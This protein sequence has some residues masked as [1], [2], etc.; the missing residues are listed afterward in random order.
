MKKCLLLG[1]IVLFSSNAA[2]NVQ[3]T[4]YDEQEVANEI[5]A[6]LEK[7]LDQYPELKETLEFDIESFQLSLHV[8][9]YLLSSVNQVWAG[10]SNWQRY[11]LEM[12]VV[13][14]GSRDIM[15]LNCQVIVIYE[16]SAHSFEMIFFEVDNVVDR[17]PIAPCSLVHQEGEEIQIFVNPSVN[18]RYKFQGRYI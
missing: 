11:A 12:D 14:T 9:L 1:V 10:T 7:T 8:P 6:L 15:K 3:W 18:P 4:G 5:P 17:N 13:D 16:A 2:A